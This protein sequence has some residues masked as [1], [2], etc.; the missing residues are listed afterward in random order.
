LMKAALPEMFTVDNVERWGDR[1]YP[2]VRAQDLPSMPAGIANGAQVVGAFRPEAWDERIGPLVD[3]VQE[4]AP[5]IERDLVPRFR[6][7]SRARYY[8]AWLQFLN[9]PRIGGD[10]S[11]PWS[12]LLGDQTP[13]FAIV[14][15]T[16]SAMTFD[17][18]TGE[19]PL[20]AQSVAHVGGARTDYL[21]HLSPMATVLNSRQAEPPPPLDDLEG[22]FL[23][24]VPV[25]QEGAEAPADQLGN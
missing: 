11:A 22:I 3:A 24:P 17:A 13:Y 8:Q 18:G 1:L 19:R 20:W 9:Q 12:L 4:V 7:A 15:K 6:T 23:R 2:P 25:I 21:A 16:S 14:D 5:E 10:P